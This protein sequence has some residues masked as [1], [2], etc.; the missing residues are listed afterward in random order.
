MIRILVTGS[1]NWNDTQVIFNDLLHFAKFAQNDGQDI[2]LVHGACP[3][4]ADF[5]AKEIA[6]VLNYKIEP[7]PADWNKYGKKA[8]FIRNK[9][10]VDLGARVC[11]AYILDESRG[12]M[13]TF[14]KAREAKIY[15]KAYFYYS[16][17]PETADVPDGLLDSASDSN[18]NSVLASGEDYPAYA[19]KNSSSGFSTSP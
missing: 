4:G 15:T 18:P 16:A 5:I 3:T 7:H 8:G 10:M 11:L 17:N 2:T 6:E 9:E 19:D 13:M 12:S 14:H 1:R